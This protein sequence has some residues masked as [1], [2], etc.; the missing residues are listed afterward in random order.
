MKFTLHRPG[1]VHLVRG[2]APGSIRIGADEYRTSL[3][4][5]ADRLVTEWPPERLTDLEREHIEAILD[6]EPDIVLLG[7]GVTQQFP[8]AAVLAPLYERGIGVEIMDTGAACR[9]YNV[10]VSEDRRVVAALL[11]A[12]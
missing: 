12:E 5:S 1:G 8:D 4:V 7:S 6:F 10:L 11:V 3:L 9:T 2:Y